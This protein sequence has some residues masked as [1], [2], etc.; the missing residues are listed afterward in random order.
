M[1]L[2]AWS[3]SSKALNIDQTHM[4]HDCPR[5]CLIISA[6]LNRKIGMIAEKFCQ[7]RDSSR[8]NKISPLPDKSERAPDQHVNTSNVGRDAA[9]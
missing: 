5:R 8:P 4:R 2:A 1:F 3:P 9:S 6:S 7:R